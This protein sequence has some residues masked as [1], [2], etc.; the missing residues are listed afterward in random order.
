[1][2]IEWAVALVGIMVTVLTVILGWMGTALWGIRGDLREFITR[3]ECI[4]KMAD[5]CSEI[6][7]LRRIA[8]ENQK[9]IAKLE[10]VALTEHHVKI[11]D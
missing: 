9:K 11:G 8:K 5:H 10:V 3:P 2:S 1:M 4:A 7:E 6:T